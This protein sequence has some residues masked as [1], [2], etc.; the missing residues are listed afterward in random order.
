MAVTLL[1]GTDSVKPYHLP[2]LNW[3]QI[4]PCAGCLCL[5]PFGHRPRAGFDR[6]HLKPS[7]A[8]GAATQLLQRQVTEMRH[9]GPAIRDDACLTK[10]EGLK[11]K[12]TNRPINF[13][14]ATVQGKTVCVCVCVC[15]LFGWN[16]G[17]GKAYQR[18]Q[19]YM[20]CELC[21]FE[22]KQAIIFA[23]C[24]QMLRQTHAAQT[25]A[26]LSKF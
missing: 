26:V 11:N 10:T 14:K 22:G 24:P 4:Q 1:K 20:S 25:T 9:L 21:R 17:G 3:S 5:V 18:F 15:A 19:F 12:Q 13:M 2:K 23:G 7:G 8:P 16:G 6:P